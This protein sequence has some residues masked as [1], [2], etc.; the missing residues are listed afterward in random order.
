M[1]T[2]TI[3][4]ESLTTVYRF[5]DVLPDPKTP[6]DPDDPKTPKDPGDPQPKEPKGGH[7]IDWLKITLTPVQGPQGGPN[8]N[9]DLLFLSAAPDGSLSLPAIPK[10]ALVTDLLETS[11]PTTVDSGVADLIVSF[12]GEN[13]AAA[14]PEPSS[15]VVLLI[16]V[17][18]FGFAGARHRLSISWCQQLALRNSIKKGVVWLAI[19]SSLS[20]PCAVGEAGV[21]WVSVPGTD[22]SS[23]LYELDSKNGN[24]LGSIAVPYLRADD[25]SFAK[26]GSIWLPDR[27]TGYVHHIDSEGYLIDSYYV[28]SD[29]IALTV[30]PDNRIAVGFDRYNVVDYLDPTTGEVSFGFLAYGPVTGLTSNDVNRTFS[31]DI[32]GSIAT[33]DDAGNLLDVLTTEATGELAGLAYSGTSFFI[34]SIGGRIQEVDAVSGQLI[35]SFAGPS[36]MTGLDFLDIDVPADGNPVPEPASILIVLAGLGVALIRWR[37]NLFV[38]DSRP[39]L[40]FSRSAITTVAEAWANHSQTAGND[41]CSAKPGMALTTRCGSTDQLPQRTERRRMTFVR[42]VYCLQLSK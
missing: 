3:A 9:V 38:A 30:L 10:S 31:L 33:V 21:L 23:T 6:K 15:L 19:V 24:I 4:A 8:M 34:A 35:N 29:A 5:F 42:S 18:L 11:F 32:Y 39:L 40:G 41:A 27:L 16:L 2:G 12:T 36:G 20:A 37:Q 25:V 14:V 26:N 1:S 13:H 7:L 28:G 17:G 22:N